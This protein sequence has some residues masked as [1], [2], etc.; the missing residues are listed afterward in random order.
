[1]SVTCTEVPWSCT[2]SE[3]RTSLCVRLVFNNK[4][5]LLVFVKGAR[6][7]FWPL[8]GGEL[9]FGEGTDGDAGEGAQVM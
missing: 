5:G 3:V 2:L 9:Q 4:G 7:S 6:L 1:M 8:M